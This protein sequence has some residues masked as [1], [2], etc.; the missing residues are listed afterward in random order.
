[1]ASPDEDDPGSSAKSRARVLRRLREAVR[2]ADERPRLVLAARL[3]RQLLPGDSEF[4]DPLSTAGGEPSH[5]LGRQVSSLGAKRPSLLGELGLGTLQVWQALSEAQ[6]RGRGRRELAILFTDLVGFSRWALEAGDTL[7]VEL[8]REVGWAVEP[9][10]TDHHGDVVKRLG[11][12]LM[13][14]FDDPSHAVDAALEARRRTREVEV[15]GHRP[16]LR[17]GIHLG[18][19]RSLGGDYLGVDVNTAARIAQAAAGGEILV[20]GAARGRLGS[21]PLELRERPDLAAKDAP[22]GLAVYSVTAPA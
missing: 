10:V 4:G 5:L 1:V 14:V 20:S 21:R 7:A 16:E 18:R 8:L 22:E 11:D 13:A 6:G 19:P 15:G 12:G 17:A 2:R 3:G 9:A